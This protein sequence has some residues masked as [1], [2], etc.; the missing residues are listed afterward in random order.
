MAFGDR[1]RTRGVAKGIE[2]C[3][4]CCIDQGGGLLRCPISGHRMELTQVDLR[5]ALA[6]AR[7]IDRRGRDTHEITEVGQSLGLIA[8]PLPVR[9]HSLARAATHG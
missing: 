4:P 1:R 5:S 9:G 2:G 8:Q 3:R 6:A 7:S